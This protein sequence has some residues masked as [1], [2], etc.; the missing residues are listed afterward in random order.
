ML[1]AQSVKLMQERKIN[2]LIVLDKQH[3]PVGAFNM[4]DVLKAGVV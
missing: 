1:V 4:H 3:R 2:A